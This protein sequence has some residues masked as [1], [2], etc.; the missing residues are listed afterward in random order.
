MYVIPNTNITPRGLFLKYRSKI[1]YGII[2]LTAL[3]RSCTVLLLTQYLEHAF[4][5]SSFQDADISLIC[6][7]NI[8]KTASKIDYLTISTKAT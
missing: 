1:K 4:L 7:T 2:H 6:T 3:I 5:H 8:P